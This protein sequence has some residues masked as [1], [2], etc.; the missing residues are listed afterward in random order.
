MAACMSTML[1][2]VPLRDRGHD[3]AEKMPWAALEKERIVALVSR[4][5]W[6]VFE[7]L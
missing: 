4:G 7:P 6:A 3:D 1:V 5:I 2:N